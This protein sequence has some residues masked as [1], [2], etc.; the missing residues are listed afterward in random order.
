MT[1]ADDHEL[2]D[3]VHELE[4]KQHAIELRQRELESVVWGDSELRDNGIRSE[5]RAIAKVVDEACK[6]VQE[7]NG[8][9]KAHV[10]SKE[11]PEVTAA[12]FNAKGVILAATIPSTLTFIIILIQLI[13][14]LTSGKGS[15]G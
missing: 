3:R 6:D 15:T 7:L 14:S 13:M 11:D 1:E 8:D 12:K 9:L 4:T 10:A 5:V 2:R